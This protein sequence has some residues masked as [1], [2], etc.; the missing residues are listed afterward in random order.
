MKDQSFGDETLMER[1]I[2]WKNTWGGKMSESSC[3]TKIKGQIIVSAGKQ[4]GK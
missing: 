2:K 4:E 1:A 3:G